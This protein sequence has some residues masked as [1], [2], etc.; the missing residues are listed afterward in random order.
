MARPAPQT[1]AAPQLKQ[2]ALELFSALPKEYDE[3]G[4]LLSFGQD[5]RWRR[6]T[7]RAIRAEPSDRVLDVATGTG[8]VAAEL[9]RRYG[10]A[11]VGIDQSEE[12]L[13][14][15][16]SRLAREPELG[17]RIELLRGEAEKLPFADA[18]FDG[19]TTAY[20]F[21]YV[22][23]PAVTLRELAR[24]VRPGG[25]IACME[26]GVPPFAPA[27]GLWKLYTRF[28]LPAAGRLV[29]RGWYQIGRFL[30]GS[31]PQYYERFPLEV[32][33]RFWEDAGIRSV[34]I[35]RMSFGAGIVISGTRANG[36][37]AG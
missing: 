3:M 28:G 32:Q 20:L 29:S 27:R 12:M 36:F 23:D 7:V 13:A 33:R 10:C 4:W 21:R 24:V 22:D 25:R 37:A 5:R 34:E 15:A 19:L 14:R 8:L 2:Q 6:A 30:S 35:R 16:R 9:V 11:V 17:Q 18:E 26:F 31:I 1:S